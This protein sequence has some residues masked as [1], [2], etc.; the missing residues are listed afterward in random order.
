MLNIELDHVLICC[1]VGGP[2]ADFLLN[3]GLLDGSG[4]THPGQGTANR[5]FFFSNAYLELLWVRDAAEAQ[6]AAVVPT[7]LWDRWLRR[8]SGACP[9]G[10]V[11][12]PRAEPIGEAPFPTWSYRPSYLPS[13]LC[14]EVGRGMALSEPQLFY[15]PFARRQGTSPRQPTDHP[16]KIGAI[17]GVSVAL[18]PKHEAS[19]TLQAA[20]DGGLLSIASGPEYCL[21]LTFTGDGRAIDFRP[22]LPLTFSRKGSAA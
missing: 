5:R 2:E 4:N 12:R 22:E 16:A 13:G 6:S 17:G 7:Q 19:Q 9:F 15:L 14:I 21:D 18:P 11:Y 20:L 10:I 3:R 1:A 8:S